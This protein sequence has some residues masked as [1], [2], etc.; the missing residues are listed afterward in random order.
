MHEKQTTSF[1][2]QRHLFIETRIYK[3]MSALRLLSVN[4]LAGEIIIMYRAL[5]KVVF[6][7]EGNIR[8]CRDSSIHFYHILKQLLLFKLPFIDNLKVLVL[9]KATHFWFP[10]KYGSDQIS[11]DLLLFF[12]TRSGVP[13]L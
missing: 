13:F 7:H 5:G 3:S 2:T 8:R 4:E 11:S 1:P 6:H 10:S 12:L 9:K